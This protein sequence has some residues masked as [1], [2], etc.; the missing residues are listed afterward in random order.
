MFD[1]F[2]VEQ[3]L[4]TQVFRDLDYT[5]LSDPRSPGAPPFREGGLYITHPGVLDPGA[6]LRLVLLASSYDGRGAFSRTF[7]SFDATWR[8]PSAVYE[9]EGWDPEIVAAGKAWSLAPA[10]TAAVAA[11]LLFVT[12]LFAARRWTTGNMA[13]L[14]RLHVG[15]MAVSAVGLGFGL[16]VQPS[17]TQVLTLVDSALHGW[18]MGL[19]LSDPVL[20]L[21]WVFIAFVTVAWGRGVFCGWVCPFGAMTEL[22]FKLGRKLGLPAYELPESIHGVAKYLRYL[23]FLGLLAA[24]LFDAQLGEQLA[25]V[26]PFKS[27]FYVPIWTRHPALIAWWLSIVGASMVWWRPYCRYVCPLGAALAA[28]STFRISGPYRRDFCSK[29]KICTRGCEPKAIGPDGRIDPRECL[30]CMEC[31]ANWRDDQVCP[32]LVKQRRDR[33]RAE[34]A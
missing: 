19:F 11:W 7:T 24:F 32:P 20:F 21:S 26:E 3:G 13:R 16:G 28:P 22:L 8:A 6:P 29:C 2:R 15:T 18:R 27:T 9:V 10:R 34:V 30:S 23:V 14:K 33:E 31:E 5:N 12:G 4:Q 17:V 25:E 1:R